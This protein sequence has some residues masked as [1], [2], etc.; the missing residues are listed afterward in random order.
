[1]WVNNVL[2]FPILLQSGPNLKVL[3]LYSL[4]KNIIIH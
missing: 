1:M 4:E 3:K 2:L